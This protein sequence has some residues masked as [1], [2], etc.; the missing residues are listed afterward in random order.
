MLASVQVD[1]LAK[2]HGKQDCKLKVILL[3]F[4]VHFWNDPGGPGSLTLRT[5][6]RMWKEEPTSRNDF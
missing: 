3:G 5:W 1:P 6:R 4:Q 2:S